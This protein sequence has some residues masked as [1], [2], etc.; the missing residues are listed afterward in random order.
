MNT[1]VT[2][3]FPAFVNCFIVQ[4]G[5]HIIESWLITINLS[6][7][8][9]SALREKCPNTDQKKL[10]FGH[11]MQW[12]YYWFMHYYFYFL[13]CITQKI[14]RKLSIDERIHYF[15]PLIKLLQET[16]NSYF[17][18]TPKNHRLMFV[19]LKRLKKSTVT[20]KLFV[21]FNNLGE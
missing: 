1:S 12:Y 17:C 11:F 6:I 21:C 2:K 10:V 16:R 20:K 14:V 15:P 5:K 18:L 7:S 3:G 8:L 9:S 19:S 13:S 4:N